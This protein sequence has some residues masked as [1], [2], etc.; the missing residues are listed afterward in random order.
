MLELS[1]GPTAPAAQI[2]VGEPVPFA[3]VLVQGGATVAVTLPDGAALQ[4]ATGETNFTQTTMPGIYQAKVGMR[5]QRFA[6]NLDAMESRTAPVPLDELERLGVPTAK[7]E[8][9]APAPAAKGKPL[10]Q[11]TELESRQKLWRWFILATLGVLL[12]ETALAG[13][14]A[15]KSPVKLEATT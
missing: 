9:A 2:I 3:A 14:T 11:S 4:L 12:L 7:T 5:E 13:W 10:T 6:V 1:G 8:S 15:R